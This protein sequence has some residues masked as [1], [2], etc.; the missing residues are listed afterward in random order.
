MHAL[1]I[2]GLLPAYNISYYMRANAASRDENRSKD[3]VF[4]LH[5]LQKDERAMRVSGKGAD[6]NPGRERNAL[7]A[8][9]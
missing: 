9:R 7:R 5:S 6:C 4:I 3:L 1:A 2:E 8:I